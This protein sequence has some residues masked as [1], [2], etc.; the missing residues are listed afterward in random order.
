MQLDFYRKSLLL[1]KLENEKQENWR[2][3]PRWNARYDCILVLEWFSGDRK[4]I[5]FVS[6]SNYRMFEQYIIKEKLNIVS[7]IFVV[8]Y[9]DVWKFAIAQHTHHVRVVKNGN[10]CYKPWRSHVASN[11]TLLGLSNMTCSIF[12]DLNTRGSNENM[13]LKY[14]SLV[15]QH[16]SRTELAKHAGKRARKLPPAKGS[17]FTIPKK[18]YCF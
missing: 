4:L 8:F 13:E 9:Q 3:Q 5:V 7:A 12:L 17:S 1:G 16:R 14:F 15:L 18:K 6:M 11:A 10:F 2:W